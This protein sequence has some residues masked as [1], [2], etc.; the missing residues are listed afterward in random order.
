MRSHKRVIISISEDGKIKSY[1]GARIHEVGFVYEFG[2]GGTFGA[3]SSDPKKT[4]YH[5]S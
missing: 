2:A 1:I 3:F 5:I 4:K